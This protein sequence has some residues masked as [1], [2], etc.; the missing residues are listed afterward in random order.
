M[1]SQARKRVRRN[2]DPNE[3]GIAS[4]TARS[5]SANS[6][7]NP[8]LTRT[9]PLLVSQLFLGSLRDVTL[10][11]TC[12][13]VCKSWN[14][15]ACQSLGACSKVFLDENSSSFNNFTTLILKKGVGPLQHFPSPFQHFHVR[16]STF[17]NQTFTKFILN[18]PI[19]SLALNLEAVDKDG[20]G[21]CQ[22]QLSN[23]L[24]SNKTNITDLEI[25]AWKDIRN[26]ES[27]FLNGLLPQVQ[28]ENLTEL[29]LNFWVSSLSWNNYLDNLR[30]LRLRR[31]IFWGGRV[32]RRK[33]IADFV[34][35][36]TIK[37]GVE[38][39]LD[40]LMIRHCL[41]KVSKLRQLSF[42]WNK[43]LS[44]SLLRD[45]LGHLQRIVIYDHAR[46]EF[47]DAMAQVT[48][49]LPNAYFQ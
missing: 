39:T 4:E 11:R 45:S 25:T 43:D 33:S 17:T 38:F 40:P 23:F 2:E 44:A 37:L 6:N 18:I 21:V 16:G 13:L 24:V 10:L 7:D 14:I 42:Y 46:Q 47:Q 3:K 26:T 48:E 36:E 5:N 28:A 20:L 1:D 35:L 32:P 41:S 29:K 8:P 22:G 30:F 31:L 27:E 9:M 12:R 34:E 15:E 49:T 19:T